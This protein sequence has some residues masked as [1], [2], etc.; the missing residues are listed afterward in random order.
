M[1][2]DT[3]KDGMRKADMLEEAFVGQ[4][5]HGVNKTAFLFFDYVASQRY[6][7]NSKLRDAYCVSLDRRFTEYA[8]ETRTKKTWRGAIAW[9]VVSGDSAYRDFKS[10]VVHSLGK[11]N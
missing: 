11:D 9:Y 1:K 10:K 5:E 2:R 3:I 8:K 4:F 7:K 6:M